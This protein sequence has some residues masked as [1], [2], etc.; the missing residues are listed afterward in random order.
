M[1]YNTCMSHAQQLILN[2]YQPIATAGTGGFGTVQVAWDTRIQRRVAIKCIELKD[3]EVARAALPGAN[4]PAVFPSLHNSQT[5]EAFATKDGS[6]DLLSGQEPPRFLAHIP[7][8]DEA[9]TAAMLSDASI[10]TVY[11]FEIQGSTAYLIM[12]YVEGMTLT[13]LLNTYGDRLTLD[14]IAAIFL[15]I[16]HALEVA[17]AHQVLHLDIK[18]DN[19]LINLEGKVKVTDFGLA[20][21]AD[22][23]GFGTAGGGTIGYM[24][25]EQMRQENLDVRCD[26]WA[27]ASLTYEM[28][29]GKNPFLAPTLDQAARAVEEGELIVPS[30][31]WSDLDPAIDDPLF[32]ALDPDCEQRYA[33]IAE[34]SGA[35]APYLG[36]AKQGKRE[37]ATL[38]G[39]ANFEQEVQQEK[40][41]DTFC[42]PHIPFRSRISSRFLAGM[43]RIF[44]AL[45]G[46][47]VAFIALF[48]I[49][50]T[51]GFENPF[52][53]GPLVVVM[54]AGV[55]RPHLSALLGYSALACAFIAHGVPA[56]G[57]VLLVATFLWWYGIG[58]RSCAAANV[59][60]AIPFAGALGCG[61]FGP[62]GAGFC[63]R[64][65]RALGTLAFVVL[66]SFCLA[67]CASHSLLFW[68]AP[69]LF[70]HA[71]GV[72]S[73]SSIQTA[74][75]TLLANPSLWCMVISWFLATGVVSAF[76]LRPTRLFALLGVVFGGV[77]LIGGLCV[78]TGVS[79]YQTNWVPEASALVAIVVP[80][81][82]MVVAC[83]LLPTTMRSYPLISEPFSSAYID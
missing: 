73:I 15:S 27:L 63:Q 32:Y 30:L 13:K 10:V 3:A 67:A 18:P 47:F 14:S 16:A 34:F 77:F 24:P 37:L 52:F 41:T 64:P 79:S 46:G 36:D 17:H 39:G 83:A 42:A 38:V 57:V 54:L 50:Q 62:L 53:W 1:P 25:P 8:L 45:S 19:V 2:R 4:A 68:N 69:F 56:L 20:T 71:Q 58:R 6:L 59:A 49:P 9:R 76:R 66:I 5:H 80:L 61:G 55:L 70:V 72:G 82:V 35:C 48:S 44:A 21:L 12:E 65:P 33:S 31:C 7:G 43:A 60:L 28:L 26:E 81:V 11:D 23:S 75:G 40:P 22:A 29:V 74:A 51:S 78:A